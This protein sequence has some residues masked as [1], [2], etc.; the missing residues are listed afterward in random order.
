[1]WT[2]AYT[3]PRPQQRSFTGIAGAWDTLTGV[4]LPGRGGTQKAGVQVNETKAMTHSTVWACL[5]LRADLISTFPAD[6]YRDLVI[7]DRLIPAEMPKPPIM[8]DP[9][10]VEWDFI[11]WMWASQRDLDLVGNCIGIIVERNGI[12]TRYYPEGLPS[13]IELCDT[14]SVAV[15]Q[16]NG[17]RRYRIDGTLYRP[18]EVYHERQYPLSGSPVGLSPLIM[19]AASVGE[20]LAMQQFGLD[21]FNAGGVPKAWMQNTRKT[22]QDGERDSAKQWYADTIR[23][24]D[25]MV[26]GRDWE[27]NMIQAETAGMEWLM[28][29][30][31]S[32]TEICQ[33]FAVPPE[34]VGAAKTGQNITYANVTQAN[35]EFL[36]L[37]L[38]AAVIRRERSLTKLLPEPRYVKL[39]TDAM[40]RM[41]PKTRQEIIR[42]RIETWTI[43]NSEARDLENQPPLNAA[44]IAEMQEIYGKPKAGGASSGGFGA[45]QGNSPGESESEPSEEPATAAA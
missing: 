7:G 18:N 20:S 38:D 19:S 2:R 23:N 1:M 15:V 8:V 10:G 27:Y 28:G 17:Q 5:R 32:R 14:R 34:M 22:L 33:F 35:L 43:T 41:D 11:D 45:G 37:N 25:L 39:N 44:D 9:G 42:S 21:W 16:K 40:L 30:E 13:K 24:G 26:T 31:Y 6:V 29:R 3:S 12:K 36:I 4:N